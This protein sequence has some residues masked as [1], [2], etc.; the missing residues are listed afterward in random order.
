MTSSLYRAKSATRGQ[1]LA[2]LFPEADASM[3]KAWIVK[4]LE[5]TSVAA[6]SFPESS[7]KIYT[8]VSS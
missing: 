3:L 7:I 6:K 1:R 8:D 2:M 5:N 4:R